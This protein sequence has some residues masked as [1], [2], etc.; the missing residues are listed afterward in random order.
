MELEYK[1]ESL[2]Y[3]SRAT[4]VNLHMGSLSLTK[5]LKKGAVTT[6]SDPDRIGANKKLLSGDAVSAITAAQRELG[7][8]IKQR[9]LP[10]PFCSGMLLIPNTL[11]KETDA[12]LV[13]AQ[14][15]LENL[16]DQFLQVYEELIA[17]DE[18]ALKSNFNRDD[19]DTPGEIRERLQNH[20]SYVEF[21]IPQSLPSD[22]LAREQE[23]ARAKFAET[24]DTIQ[25]VLRAEMSKLVKNAMTSLAA[26]TED[27][28]PKKFQNTTISN[29]REFLDL[30]SDRNITEDRELD[31]IV[32]KARQLLE[33]VNPDDLRTKAPL[34]D[35]LVN[36]FAEMGKTLETM[37]VPATIRRITFEDEEETANG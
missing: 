27:G 2:G 22:V 7:K 9:T 37:I 31:E 3:L 11:V 34:R 5:K 12:K 4:V 24:T 1:R 13:A 10:S 28:K 20:W 18:A 33:G 21:S 36:G 23:K 6:D 30:F 8:W 15:R 25:Q 29:I 26:K 14:A 35:T 16:T 32:A 19:Y 17:A